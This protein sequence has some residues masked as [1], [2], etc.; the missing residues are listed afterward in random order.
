MSDTIKWI[1]KPEPY[2]RWERIPYEHAPD[3][4]QAAYGPRKCLY[5]LRD[6][7]QFIWRDRWVVTMRKDIVCDLASVPN[8]IPRFIASKTQRD[9]WLDTG[10]GAHDMGHLGVVEFP[11][12]RR[13]RRQNR[14]FDALMLDLWRDAMGERD[15]NRLT[16]WWRHGRPRRKYWGVRA[17][18][19]LL[20]RPDYGNLRPEWMTIADMEREFRIRN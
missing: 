6:D 5:L 7:L 11:G 20:W 17:A 18:S 14:L 10:A 4:V 9:N 13:G 16:R 1:Q 3:F 12:V 2:T 19:P 15:G 8:L